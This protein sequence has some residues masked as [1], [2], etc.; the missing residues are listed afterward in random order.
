MDETTMGLYAKVCR[1][2]HPRRV[3][4]NA[5]SRWIIRFSV[6]VAKLGIES[7]DYVDQKRKRQRSIFYE[8][9]APCM[10]P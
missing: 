5:L 9:R 6:E 3:G 1:Y 2:A 4:E 7:A 8:P 10:A